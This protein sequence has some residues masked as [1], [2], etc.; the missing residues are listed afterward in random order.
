[1]SVHSIIVCGAGTMGSGIAQVSA[2]HGHQT[3]LFDPFDGAIA[4]ARSKMEGGLQSLVEKGK[5]SPSGRDKT[6]RHLTYTDQLEA[7]MPADLVI[8]AIV[9]QLPAKIQLF[10]SLDPIRKPST[11]WASNTSSLSINSLQQAFK[12]PERIAGMHFFNPALLMRLVE[13]VAGQATAPSVLDT[14]SDLALQWNKV[15]VICKDAPGFIVNRVARAYYLEAL[16]MLEEGAC[17]ME[18]IDRIAEVSG[19]KMGPFRLMDLIGNDINLAVSQSLY[20]ASGFEPRFRPS[21]IQQA[22]VQAGELGRK[23]AKGYYSYS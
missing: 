12:H 9:E 1:M 16:Q 14:L 13:V 11:I 7:L 18:S 10:A 22:K 17:A 2:M 5:M 21:P 23:T 20:E 6:L 19:F 15:P 3:T 4:K 8:E